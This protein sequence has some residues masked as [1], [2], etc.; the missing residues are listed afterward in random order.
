MTSCAHII[1]TIGLTQGR[2]PAGKTR[3]T[4]RV[5]I[6]S[7]RLV[8]FLFYNHPVF[9]LQFSDNGLQYY[10]TVLA[11]EMGHNLGMNHDDTRCLCQGST[12]IMNSAATS[13]L[14][15]SNSNL[16]VLRF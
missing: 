14:N 15:T 11:H 1:L 10:S 12:C 7:K 4:G 13:V 6:N 16:H 5:G 2:G 8:C 9:T 3:K